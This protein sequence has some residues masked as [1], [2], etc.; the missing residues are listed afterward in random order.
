MNQRVVEMTWISDDLNEGKEEHHDDHHED[1][2][3]Q[4]ETPPVVQFRER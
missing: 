2:K 4:S 1:V 3:H